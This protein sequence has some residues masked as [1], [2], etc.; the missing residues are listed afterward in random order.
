VYFLK[1]HGFLCA[2][3]YTIV[4][5]DNTGN[6]LLHKHG[7]LKTFYVSKVIKRKE[8]LDF[9]K[10][11]NI[12]PKTADEET[13]ERVQRTMQA[14]ANM[15]YFR[16]NVPGILGEHPDMEHQIDHCSIGELMSLSDVI[17]DMLKSEGLTPRECGFVLGSAIKQ[18]NLNNSDYFKGFDTD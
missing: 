15:G 6:H 11:L 1:I 3:I 8:V 7:I 14:V 10:K 12:D 18:L 4:S 2:L 17:T 13:K 9:Y 16:N 5:N